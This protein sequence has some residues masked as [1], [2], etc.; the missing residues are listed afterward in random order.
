MSSKPLKNFQ[1]RRKLVQEK[2][3]L[4]QI[5]KAKSNQQLRFLITNAT[6][7]QIRLMQ[8]LI[9][10]YFSSPEIPISPASYRQLKQTR[11]LAFLKKQFKPVKTLNSLAEARALL[12]KVPSCVRILVSNI[13]SA[14]KA[15]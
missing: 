15:T 5:R 11:K 2:P 6:N 13:V 10:G 1:L 4:L 3:F 7:Q 9:M 8:S 14:K 12:Y